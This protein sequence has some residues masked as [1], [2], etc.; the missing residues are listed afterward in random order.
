LS[1]WGTGCDEQNLNNAQT[2]TQALEIWVIYKAFM[3]AKPAVQLLINL[4][5]SYSW[6]LTFNCTSAK[7][8]IIWLETLLPN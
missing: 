2:I 5:W 6:L 1:V 4:V 3:L 8:L 7:T